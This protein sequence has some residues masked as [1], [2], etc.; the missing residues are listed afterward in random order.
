[1][2]MNMLSERVFRYCR[3]YEMLPENADL[4]CGVSGGADSVALLFLLKEVIGRCPQKNLTL[5]AVHV[6]HG[7]RGEESLKD[8]AFTECLCKSLR[9]PLQI[10]SVDAVAFAKEKGLGLEEAA[11]I[12]RYKAFQTAAKEHRSR[13]VLAHHMDDNAETVLFQMARGSSIHGL[14][15]IR[16]VRTDEA[17]YVYLRPLLCLQKRELEFYLREIGQDWQTDATNADTLYSRNRIRHMVLPELEEVNSQ[18]IRHICR[19]AEQLSEIEDF[20]HLQMLQEYRKRVKKEKNRWEL[21]LSGFDSCHKALRKELLLELLGNVCGRRKDLGTVH[22][23]QM[24]ELCLGQSGKT[25]CFPYNVTAIREFDRLFLYRGKEVD[26]NSGFKQDI[27]LQAEDIGIKESVIKESVIE[28]SVIEESIIEESVTKGS[29]TEESGIKETEKIQRIPVPGGCIFL[30]FFHFDGD[31]G[32][33][34]KNTYTKW[35]DYDKIKNGFCFRTRKSG[36]YL[37]IDSSGHR[38]KLKTYLI[39]EKIPVSE[40]EKILLMAEGQ[41]ILWVIGGRLSERVKI[42]AETARV[43]AVTYEEDNKEGIRETAEQGKRSI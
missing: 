8:A 34:P 23:K 37:I 12:L 41:E 7:I 21:N 27:S 15:G 24:E 25:V 16:P 3:E 14:C 6:E 32:K 5:R 30:Q 2:E 40:R 29:G 31:I 13:I 35:L 43:L 20:L 26:I 19:T 42:T 18:A 1:M 36:D 9:I 10:F 11:R 28:E 17:G 4:L 39:D 22:I 33:I 38:K